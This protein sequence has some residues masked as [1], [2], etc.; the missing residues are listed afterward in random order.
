MAAQVGLL[1]G[2]E[3]GTPQMHE[4]TATQQGDWRSGMRVQ[5][6]L[7]GSP[8]LWASTWLISY[9]VWLAHGC[10]AYMP[11]VSDFGAAGGPTGLYFMIGMNAAALLWMP[12]WFDYYFATRPQ[13][14]ANDPSCSELLRAFECKLHT[15][16]PF[17]GVVCSLG[18]IGVASNPEDRNLIVHGSSANLAFMSG[19]VFT[20]ISAILR[21]RRGRPW[22]VNAS[23]AVVGIF[24]FAGMLHVISTTIAAENVDMAQGLAMIDTDFV[25]CSPPSWSRDRS[26]LVC[27]QSIYL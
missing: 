20:S 5:L 8:L 14:A 7:W 16:Q 22:K 1:E 24:S 12:T 11:M 9:A 18:I 26:T 3:V 25:R 19:L 13:V 10:I 17:I 6:C 15:L 21:H 27:R 2:S 23:L 4:G